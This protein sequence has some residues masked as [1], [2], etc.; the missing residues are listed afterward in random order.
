MTASRAQLQQDFIRAWVA[1]KLREL[2][3]ALIKAADR[4]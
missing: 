3:R 1:V 2:G 4:L